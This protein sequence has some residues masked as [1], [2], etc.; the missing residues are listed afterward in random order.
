MRVRCEG[1]I[2]LLLTSSY[3]VFSTLCRFE[4]CDRIE[5]YNLDIHLS[6][7]EMLVTKVFVIV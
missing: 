5:T 7:P 6:F 1:S 2:V 3:K 4:F